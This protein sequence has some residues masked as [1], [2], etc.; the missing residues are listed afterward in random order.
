MKLKHKLLSQSIAVLVLALML[1]GYILM[2]MISIQSSN[3]EYAHVLIGVQRLDAAV[4]TGQQSLNNYAYNQTEMNRNAAVGQL[5]QIRERVN[6]L[7]NALAGDVNEP[8]FKQVEEKYNLLEAGALTALEERNSTEVLRQ[9]VRSLGI[10][11]DLHLLN[12]ET[13]A[14]YEALT[15]HSNLALQ[16]L[17]ITT[18][19]SS[20]LLLVAALIISFWTT[21]T[22][23]APIRKIA[24]QAEKVASGNLVVE[25]MEVKTKDEIGSLTLS[26]VRMVQ[27]L[28]SLIFSLRQASEEMSSFSG[29]VKKDTVHLFETSKQVM[30]STEE[31]AAGT[32]RVSENLQEAVVHVESLEKAFD[33]NVKAVEEANNYGK[34]VSTAVKE[35]EAAV[36]EQRE[37]SQN[38]KEASSLLSYS[39]QSLSEN[40]QSI[41]KMAELVAGI[42]EQTNLLALNAAIE[43]ARAGEAGKGFAVVAD[44]VRKLAEQSAEA[45]RSIF[46]MT[47]SIESKMAEAK[48]AVLNGESIQSQQFEI[49]KKTETVFH[50]IETGMA[51]MTKLLDNLN[52]STKGSTEN[53]KDVLEIVESISAV[54]EQ[55]AA[56]SEE[57]SASSTEQ[58]KSTKEIVESIEKIAETSLQLEEQMKQFKTK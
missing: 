20:I 55:T 5:G 8:I 58:L 46:T 54:T 11:N 17:I 41:Q 53:V 23:T 50:A 25:E 2:S 14:Y 32:T 18:I 57:I 28:Q 24:E 19:I 43:A 7:G 9:S 33:S 45:T 27:Q 38:S 56:G 51:N 52:E 3:R 4:V 13:T 15:E 10:L 36:E 21:K 49:M 42:S 37:L 47:N 34:K 48:E 44:E 29:N 26:F 1:V 39:V 31:M 12:L 22:I 6:E 35:G 30:V 16:R 40:V